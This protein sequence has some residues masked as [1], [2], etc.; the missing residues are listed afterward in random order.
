MR[1]LKFRLNTTV[2]PFFQFFAIFYKNRNNTLVIL[3]L[4]LMMVVL[5]CDNFDKHLTTEM[6]EFNSLSQ[7]LYV[8]QPCDFCH[9]RAFKAKT[10]KLPTAKD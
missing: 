6:F 4:L 2:R 8:P 10:K 1:Q 5:Y 7:R 9:A 3:G